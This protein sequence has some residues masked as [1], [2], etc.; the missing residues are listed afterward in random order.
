MSWIWPKSLPRRILNIAVFTLLTTVAILLVLSARGVQLRAETVVSLSPGQTWE[1]FQDPNNLA[2]WDRSVAKVEVTT[3][4]P[5]GVGY[6]FDTIGPE[7][8]NGAERSS[9]RIAEFTPKRSTRIDL[10]N[11]DQFQR[12]SWYTRLEPVDGGTRVVIDIEFA[13]KPQYFF[14]TPVL[15]LSRDNLTTDME[16]LHDQIEALGRSRQR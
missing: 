10:V 1:F 6:T 7:R 12:A 9:Y 15:Y 11:S 13:P 8:P 14:L 16:Y 5:I 4:A 3:S 2:K